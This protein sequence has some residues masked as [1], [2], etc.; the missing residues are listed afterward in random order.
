MSDEPSIRAASSTSGDEF[1]E[2]ALHHPD[3][4]RQVEHGV[5]RDDARVG[6]GEARHAEHDEDRNDDHDRRQHARREDHEQI[7]VVALQRI[8]REAEGRDRADRQRKQHADPGDE[9]RIE[10][11]EREAGVLRRPAGGI[12][13]AEHLGEIVERRREEEFRRHRQRVLVGLERGQDDPEHREEIDEADDR[14]ERACVP[15]RRRRRPS[16]TG[17]AEPRRTGAEGRAAMGRRRNLTAVRSCGARLLGALA[18]E[19]EVEVGEHDHGEQQDIGE[20]GRFARLVVFEGDAI[21][22]QRNGL[23]RGARAAVA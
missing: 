3:R 20:R 9:Q 6:A 2:E 12:G 16:T 4:E 1:V 23:G 13:A 18:R 8:A 21:D 17:E 14:R 5:E 22:A 7:G 10:E 15:I 19:I 11:I